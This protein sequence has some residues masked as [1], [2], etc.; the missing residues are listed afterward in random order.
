[1]IQKEIQHL[2]WRA[3]FGIQPR[4]LRK[5][6]DKSKLSIVERLFEDSKSIT[7]LDIDLS[8]LEGI[9]RINLKENPTLAKA[10]RQKS[11]KKIFRSKLCVDRKNVEFKR[12]TSRAYDP[13]LGQSLCLQG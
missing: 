7:P 12:N 13:L 9:N 11:R 1:M 5:Q 8:F 4:E 10:L 6:L 2:Y 3:G